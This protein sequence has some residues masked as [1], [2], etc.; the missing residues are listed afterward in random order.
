M[1]E[2][3]KVKGGFTFSGCL[4]VG[5]ST[6]RN[7]LGFLRMDAQPESVEPFGQDFHYPAG[8]FFVLATD[9]EVVGK[10]H[11]EAVSFHPRLD[12]LY[13]PAI[14]Y[15]VEVDIRQHGTGYATNNIAKSHVKWGLRIDRA[16]L[17]P[18]FDGHPDTHVNLFLSVDVVVSTYKERKQ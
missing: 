15:F 11:D 5:R 12:F 18:G 8:V 17:R 4:S 1:G 14:Q 7:Q 2:A 10:P 9:N 6:E 3:E 13:K 16:C